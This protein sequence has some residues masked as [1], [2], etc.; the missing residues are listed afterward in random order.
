MAFP[1]LMTSDRVCS[2]Q[3]TRVLQYVKG[4]VLIAFK[5]IFII[6]LPVD[7]SCLQSGI[8]IDW[9]KPTT[10]GDAEIDYYQVMVGFEI[11]N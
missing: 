4:Y 8:T 5:H 7:R 10:F 6:I 2:E 11:K 9:R 1:D 3:T